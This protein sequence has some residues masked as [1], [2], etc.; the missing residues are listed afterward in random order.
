VKFAA[1]N[2][3]PVNPS[4]KTFDPDAVNWVNAP[5]YNVAAQDYVS[6]KCEDR[7]EVK[8]GIL[9]GK[10]V[11]ACVSCIATW[12]PGDVTAAKSKGGLVKVAST[13]HYLMPAVLVGPKHFLDKNRAEITALLAATMEAGD[14]LKAHDAALHKAAELSAKLYADQDAAYWYRYFKGATEKDATGISVDLGGSAVWNLADVLTQFG[15]LPGKNDNFRS[16][17]TTF[18]GYDLHYYPELFKDTPIP[19]VKEIEDKTF[20]RGAQDLLENQSLA[21]DEPK[22]EKSDIAQATVISKRSYQINF[23]TGEATLTAEGERQLQLLKD[24]IAITSLMVKIDGYTDNTGNELKVN[25][26]LSYAR[27]EAIK[28]FLQNRAP[29]NFP[30]QRFSVAGHGSSN[31]VAPNSTA[32]GRAKNRRVEI[33][34]LGQ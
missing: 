20:I 18:A 2:D 27:A 8:N 10:T 14:Q 22:F 29:E 28:T 25:V 17:Y 26:P 23:K 34:L 7:K 32:A 3:I 31:P 21:A 5:D 13:K 11:H 19:D 1:D 24:S 33:A 30:D 9:T 15:M 6:G 4:E 12:T 16:V